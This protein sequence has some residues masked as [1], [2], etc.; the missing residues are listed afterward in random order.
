MAAKVTKLEPEELNAVMDVIQESFSSRVIFTQ[1]PDNMIRH[2]TVA[3]T[4]R[5][6]VTVGGRVIHVSIIAD[7]KNVWWCLRG[8]EFHYP[9]DEERTEYIDTIDPY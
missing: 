9:T 8:A 6:A 5:S 3:Q 1:I 4:K 7:A 2:R